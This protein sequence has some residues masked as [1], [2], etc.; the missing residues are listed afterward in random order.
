MSW[1][2]S[3]FQLCIDLNNMHHVRAQVRQL[4]L[5]LDLNS[6]YKR[7]EAEAKLGDNAKDIVD[8]LLCSADD[9]FENRMKH[10]VDD[11]A[12]RMAPEIQQ[13]VEGAITAAEDTSD[14]DV[15]MVV[16]LNIYI[17]YSNCI[18]SCPY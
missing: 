1:F 4:P 14:L 3:L 9:D 16:I 12:T 2:L 11:L 10:I 8:R 18:I 17:W 15:S 6:Y 7:L 5:K 13:R